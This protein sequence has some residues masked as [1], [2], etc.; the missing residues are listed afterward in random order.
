[1]FD[2][3]KYA[4]EFVVVKERE[5]YAL[6]DYL[7]SAEGTLYIPDGITRIS[8]G[9]FRRFRTSAYKKVTKIVFPKTLKRIPDGPFCHWETLTEVVIPEGITSIVG[10]AFTG[11]ALREVTLPS[12]L[13]QLGKEVF[14]YCDQ[15]QKVTI[16]HL[17]TNLLNSLLNPSYEIPETKYDSRAEVHILKFKIFFG[18]DESWEFSQ[19]YHFYSPR[20][21]KAKFELK[22]MCVLYNN[23][24][25]G[26]VGEETHLQIPDTATAIG[27]TAFQDN[28]T[29]QSVT[30]G[31]KVKIISWSAFENC[32][33]L[34]TVTL[35][36]KLEEI[37]DFAF[38]NTG[39][40]TII[41]PPKVTYVGDAAFDD[42]RHLKSVIVE[43]A[44]I[45]DYRMDRW[46]LY[47]N[48]G[49]Y[50]RYDYKTVK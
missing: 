31:P 8:E 9:A 2:I 29:L 19:F 13:E 39:I 24:V 6:K 18:S 28:H 49:L 15:L 26:C 44:L 20:L 50:G 11:T 7:G 25:V 43:K 41:I 32:T 40:E 45:G 33:S 37:G 48:R 1:M 12:T 23:A 22:N 35:N 14:I 38:R 5:E 42:C 16:N 47:W 17:S 27:I 21:E 3:K 30:M 34:K 10:N 36:S 4:D 46:H